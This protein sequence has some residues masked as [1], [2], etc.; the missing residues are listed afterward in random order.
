MV[1]GSAS[2]IALR[3]PNVKAIQTDHMKIAEKRGNNSAINVDI[4]NVVT[5]ITIVMINI[6]S[7]L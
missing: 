5:P 6:R 7:S 3:V 2:L 1:F 4:K